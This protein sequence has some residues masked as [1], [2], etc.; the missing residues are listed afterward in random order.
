MTVCAYQNPRT[1]KKTKA[2]N[3]KLLVFVGS[4]AYMAGQ[5]NLTINKSAGTI[6]VS[7]K[8]SGGE[9]EFLYQNSTTTASVDGLVVVGDITQQAFKDAIDKKCEV[10]V[11]REVKKADGTIQTEEGWALVTNWTETANYNDV[12]QY[13]AELQMNGAF[14]AVPADIT[15]AA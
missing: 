5:K 15:Y 3:I 4:M 12:W 7:D 2:N 10:L 8:D 9:S 6:D 1:A 11:Q 14:R 13:S